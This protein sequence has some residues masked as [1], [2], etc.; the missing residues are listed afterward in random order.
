[1]LALFVKLIKLPHSISAFLAFTDHIHT[2]L[3]KGHF[4]GLCQ[5]LFKGA[6]AH[7]CATVLLKSLMLFLCPVSLSLFGII[8]KAFHCKTSHQIHF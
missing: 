1:M 5:S 2:T 4:A 7:S 8:F 6:S 3:G